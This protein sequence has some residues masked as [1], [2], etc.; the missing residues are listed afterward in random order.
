MPSKKIDGYKV[1]FYSA[2]RHEPL[3]VHVVRGEKRAKIWLRDLSIAWSRNF[4]SR[5]LNRV[6]DILRNYQAEL[7]EWYDGF[8]V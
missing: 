5:E 2:D 8:F 3:H 7:T 1:Q 6:L 4:S